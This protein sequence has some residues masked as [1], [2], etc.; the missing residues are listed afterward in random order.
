M[1]IHGPLQTR[2]ETR[3][4]GEVSVSRLASRTRRACD[5]TKV[6]IWRKDTGC[7][8]TLYRKCHSHNTPGKGI[9]TL[10]SNSYIFFLLNLIMGYNVHA[11]FPFFLF[12][13]YPIVL[14]CYKYKLSPLIGLRYFTILNTLCANLIGAMRISFD[15]L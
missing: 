6:Y 8:P 11:F 9:I 4:P 2:G 7:G 5:T 14:Y 15:Y 12:P 13:F 10:K 3:C 1:D